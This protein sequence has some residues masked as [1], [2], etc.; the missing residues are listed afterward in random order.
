MGMYL[1]AVVTFYQISFSGSDA[2]SYICWRYNSWYWNTR[3]IH[4]KILFEFMSLYLVNF[5]ESKKKKSGASRGV[6]LRVGSCGMVTILFAF[7]FGLY[8]LC[9]FYVF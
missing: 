5:S 2:K 1:M 4:G 3:E 7:N 8:H 6:S 9:L